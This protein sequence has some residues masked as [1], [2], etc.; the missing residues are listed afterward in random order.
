MRFENGCGGIFDCTGTVISLVSLTKIWWKSIDHKTCGG[1]I[2]IYGLSL[3]E[4]GR[5]NL[6]L[7]ACESEDQKIDLDE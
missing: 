2:S 1:N 5:Q 7:I 6:K 3:V 4:G